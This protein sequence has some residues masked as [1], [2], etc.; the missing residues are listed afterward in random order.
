V[1]KRWPG[2]GGVSPTTF[3]STMRPLL[4]IRWFLGSGA[5]GVSLGESKAS[6]RHM[7]SETDTS[8]LQLWATVGG[9]EAFE[10]ASISGSQIDRPGEGW[11]VPPAPP[12]PVITLGTVSPSNHSSGS[13][14]TQDSA[15]QL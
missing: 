3:S 13:Y 10:R 4:Q 15:A 1:E 2:G 5:T 9:A 7:S 14:R 12:L 11:S 8:G 6:Y